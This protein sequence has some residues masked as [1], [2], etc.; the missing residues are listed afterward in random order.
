MLI[1]NMYQA[2]AKV[3]KNPAAARLADVDY[4]PNNVL[5]AT[6]CQKS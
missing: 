3:S 6:A 5:K 2:K 1:R 4:I